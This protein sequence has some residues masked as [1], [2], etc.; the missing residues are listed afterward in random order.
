MPHMVNKQGHAQS[1]TCKWTSRKKNFKWEGSKKQNCD[2]PV[3][4]VT[5][6]L[7]L[8]LSSAS[9]RA[10]SFERTPSI[11]SFPSA[12]ATTTRISLKGISLFMGGPF[13]TGA[14]TKRPLPRPPPPP[15]LPLYWATRPTKKP[16]E[17]GALNDWG[18]STRLDEHVER[19]DG[20]DNC[21]R[22]PPGATKAGRAVV[23]HEFD[24]RSLPP[25]SWHVDEA[26]T[27]KDTRQTPEAPTVESMVLRLAGMFL[28]ALASIAQIRVVAKVWVLGD[29]IPSLSLSLKSESESEHKTGDVWLRRASLGPGMTLVKGKMH[30]SSTYSHCPVLWR[31]NKSF[32][33]CKHRFNQKSKS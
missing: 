19:W 27:K 12:L 5:S 7:L 10:S 25:S 26:R 6:G 4:W 13:A 20:L 28:E 18:A 24:P 21:K 31:K 23:C 30:D 2:G 17:R 32:R 15:P 29:T 14:T 16:F 11:V 22:N 33:L 9:L 3:F 1:M 8:T